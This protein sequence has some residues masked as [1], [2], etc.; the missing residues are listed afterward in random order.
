M[1]FHAHK[2][3]IVTSYNDGLILVA[4]EK[5][6]TLF[7]VRSVSNLS[8]GLVNGF[9]SFSVWPDGSKEGWSESDDFDEMMRTYILWLENQQHEDGSNTLDWGLCQ[10]STDDHDICAWMKT[11][12]REFGGVPPAFRTTPKEEHE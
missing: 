9:R 2:A 1:G 3:L 11:R 7:S 4:H 5:A 10:F 8:G 12:Y 6:C